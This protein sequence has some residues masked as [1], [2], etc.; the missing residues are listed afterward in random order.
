MLAPR[1]FSLLMLT[2]VTGCGGCQDTSNP[3]ATR[4]G[5]PDGVVVGDANGTST[6]NADTVTKRPTEGYHPGRFVSLP[7]RWT[8]VE[9]AHQLDP[10]EPRRRLYH[11]SFAAGGVAI[12][13]VDGDGLPDLFLV[14]TTQPNQLYRNLGDLR[15][16][17]VVDGNINAGD[18][19]GTGAAMVDIDNDGDLDIYVCNYDSP[20]QLYLNDGT[21]KFTESAAEW[22]LDI[23]DACLMP[24]F[25]DYDRDGD[26]DLYLLNN[27]YYRAEGRPS[28]DGPSST[29]FEVTNGTARVLDEFQRYYELKRGDNQ[30]ITFE[31]YGRHDRLLRNEGQQ[32]QDV[33]DISGI[34]GRGL[35]LSATWWD[36][37]DDGWPDLYVCNSSDNPDRYYLNNQDGTFSERIATDMP[38]TTWSSMGSCAGDVNNDGRLDLF[39]VDISATTH[40]AQKTTIGPL[41]TEPLEPLTRPPPQY[42]RNALFLNSG[43]PRFM[44]LAYQAGVAHSDSSWAPI[45]CDFDNDGWLD[46]FVSNGAVRSFNSLDRPITDEMLVEST[47]WDLFADEEPRP[48]E[49][50]AFANQAAGEAP[51]FHE[52]GRTW[53]LDNVGISMGAATGDLDGD[54]DMDLVVINMNQAVSIYRNDVND[55]HGLTVKLTGTQSN[56]FGVGAKVELQTSSGTQTRT[57]TPYSGFLGSHQPILHFG[58]SE[59]DA[60]VSLRIT[61]PSGVVQSIEHIPTQGTMTV[62][63]SA[64]NAMNDGQRKLHVSRTEPREPLFLR[65]P[66]PETVTHR[67]RRYDD[68]QRQPLLPYRLSQLGPGLAVGD[69]NGDGFDDLFLGGAAGQPGTLLLTEAGQFVPQDSA[70]FAADRES[71]DMGC[72]FFDVDGDEDLDLYVASGGV[73]T[74]LDSAAL[75]DRLYLNDG[76]GHFERAPHGQLPA[77]LSSS[78]TV[79]ADDFDRDGDLDLFVGTRVR[80]NHY[81]LSGASRLLRNDGGRLVD[82]SDLVAPDLK[83]AGMVTGAIWSDVDL[84]GW[85]DL[86]VTTDWGPI[87]LYRNHK[88]QLHEATQAAGLADRL[89]WWTGITGRDLDGDRDIDFIVTNFGWNTKYGVNQLPVLLYYGDFENNGDNHLVEAIHRDG[90]P[91]PVRGLNHSTAAMPSLSKR[92]QTFHDF[93]LADLEKVYTPQCLDEAKRFEVNEL[94]TGMLINLGDGTFKLRFGVPGGLTS[95]LAQIAPSFGCVVS[96]L[97]GD[98]VP[99]VFLAQNFHSPQPTTGNMDGGVGLLMIG[100]ST[101]APHE[102]ASVWPCDSGLVVPGDAKSAVLGDFDN[103][104]AIELIVAQNNGTPLR[105]EQTTSELAGEPIQVQ[106]TGAAGNRQA[107]GARVT[108]VTKDGASQTAEIHAGSGYLSQSSTR[109]TFGSS[110]LEAVETIVVHWPDGS[111]DVHSGKN[112]RA[113]RFEKE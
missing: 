60:P 34:Q 44:E 113:Y 62:E 13:D 48:E 49:N 66:F 63:E 26:L 91:Y 35:G 86:L 100:S 51:K 110:N 32:F 81:P 19:W 89:G 7:S 107:I 58:G 92:F 65:R 37:N 14:G 31:E 98:G 20:N 36:S 52:T 42:M 28:S 38:H 16:E 33:T 104:G 84:D 76:Q 108:V 82:A 70:A 97:N 12:G 11:S 40:Y 47:E 79:V 29:V 18:A 75:Q 46:L 24:S 106:L 6:G 111:H 39:A 8:G 95:N 17:E 10:G 73:E 15:F 74:D 109:I 3:P 50:L 59:S 9:F 5:A 103:N 78:S 53:G 45:L 101:T 2:V 102:L 27:R 56:R 54:G 85:R 112:I 69:V 99:D 77:N 105:F 41:S 68:F 88:G 67:E 64:V 23:V 71:E 55:G 57:L 4:D 80:P 61:W 43:T 22:N 21:A 93:A 94:A 25:A 1:H 72:L 30:R 87:R 83:Q 90:I 96:E